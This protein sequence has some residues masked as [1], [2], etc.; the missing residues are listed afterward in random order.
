M[1]D[2]PAPLTPPDCDLRGYDFMPLFGNRLFN[3]H[4]YRKAIRD[5]RAGLAAF[6]LWW[7]AWLQC[8]AGSLPDDDDDLAMLADF[9]LDTKAWAKVRSLA[10]HGFVKCSDGRLY[11][12]VLA[13]E[14]IEA[15]DRRRRERERKASNRAKKSGQPPDGGGSPKDVPRDKPG[16]GDGT[17]GGTSHASH[18][19]VPADRTGQDRTGTGQD[20]LSK[21][22]GPERDASARLV[23]QPSPARSDPPERW[24]HLA[25]RLPDGSPDLQT[26]QYPPELLERCAKHGR[27]PPP[28]PA[29]EVGRPRVAGWH[30]NVAAELV[31]QAAGIND[32]NW[33]GDW[34]PLIGWLRDGFDLHEVILPAVQAVAVRPSYRPPSSLAYFDK[35]VR[36]QRVAA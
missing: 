3:S 23:H 6:K 4:L 26:N 30:I 1:S 31:C 8:P 25:D 35:A 22:R 12:P 2:L 10:L 19:D 29:E 32:A 9:G 33:R 34:R 16:T 11:H 18:R 20:S 5:P 24:V 15:F 28:I 14:A 36:E 17:D 21:Q 7:V 13:T 27:V